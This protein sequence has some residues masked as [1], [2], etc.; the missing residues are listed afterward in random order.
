MQNVLPIRQLRQ[1][2]ANPDTPRRGHRIKV[3]L[4]L[5]QE[6]TRKRRACK[7][8]KQALGTEPG[9]RYRLTPRRSGAAQ[10]EVPAPGYAR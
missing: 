8:A 5:R 3:T 6:E 10:D 2:G 9:D 7:Q 1:A 4:L